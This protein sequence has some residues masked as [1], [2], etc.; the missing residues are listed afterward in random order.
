MAASG[1][2]LLG[3]T[4]SPSIGRVGSPSASG[5]DASAIGGLAWLGTMYAG[6]VIKVIGVRA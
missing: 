1:V 3:Y 2:Q 5:V 4:E 6:T